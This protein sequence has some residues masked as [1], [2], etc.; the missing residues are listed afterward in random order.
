[1]SEGGRIA[2]LHTLARDFVV[3]WGCVCSRPV[4]VVTLGANTRPRISSC[5]ITPLG[6]RCD[7]YASGLDDRGNGIRYQKLQDTFALCTVARPDLGLTR[8]C[9]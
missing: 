1:V 4:A 9:T 8:F 7:D 5:R 6:S 3:G 2:C